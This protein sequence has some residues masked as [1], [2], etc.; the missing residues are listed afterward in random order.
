VGLE[1]G[2]ALQLV[3]TLELELTMRASW[4]DE[5]DD[6]YRGN[7]RLRFA[8]DEFR[9]YFAQRYHGFAD[10]WVTV[11][12]DAPVERMTVTGFQLD[13]KPDD[14]AWDVWQRNNLDCDS[15]LGFLAS[16]LAGRSF[17]LVWGDPDDPDTP[18]VTFEDSGQAIVGYYPGSRYRRRAA[19]K[20]WQDGNRMYCTLYTADE[21]WR[22]ERPL[23]RVEKPFNLAQ[24][25]EEAEQWLPRD[26][27]D[28]NEP[29][30]QPNPMGLVPMV[31]IANRP[32]LAR[33]PVSDVQTIIPL[34][35]SINLLWAHLFT[36][37]DFAAL[38]QRFVIG[39]ETPKV[40][41]YAD[42]GITQVGTKAVSLEE[43]KRAR[44]LWI[45]D[46]GATAGSWPA[47]NLQIFSD[48]IETAIG[49]VA[50]QSRTP[51]HYLIGKMS[52]VG[53][54]TLLAAE[55]GLTKRVGEKLLWSGA[56]LREVMRLV[57]LAQGDQKRADAYRS[58]KVLWADTESR[59][60][61]QLVASLVQLKSIGWPFEDLA[62]RFGLTQEEVEQLVKMR[63]KEQQN[64]PLLAMLGT[65]ELGTSGLV[66]R[67]G[68][69]SLLE[70]GA[71]SP[72]PAVPPPAVPAPAPQAT[73][74]PG[75]RSKP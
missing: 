30:P 68:D 35:H 55:A 23:S 13:G 19:L 41:V 24:F 48:V 39:A 5:A 2:Q 31:E 64:D 67:G 1:I 26:P 62:R 40:P 4:A 58:G 49:H 16:V 6:W 72:P 50:A 45:Q 42:D 74:A 69:P 22:F 51:Q 7:H 59:S 46:E 36:A 28:L 38:A 12:A 66:G 47:A 25:D 56:S 37:S 11:V 3:A 57:A 61:A 43:Y 8:S 52:N 27:Y 21:L 65:K 33:E 14:A 9:D 53:S 29:N 63:D 75:A 44:L 15:Q 17:V 73:S 32:M 10:N 70:G 54:D 60:Q 18:C 20:R 71:P 34:Q